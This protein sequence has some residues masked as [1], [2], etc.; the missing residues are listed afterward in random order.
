L[1]VIEG[2]LAYGVDFLQGEGG[3]NAKVVLVRLANNA[4]HSL[5]RGRAFKQLHAVPHSKEREVEEAVL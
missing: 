2:G 3:A 5:M 4:C 1:R